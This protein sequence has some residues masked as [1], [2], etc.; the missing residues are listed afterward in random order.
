[1]YIEILFTEWPYPLLV[2]FLIF[3]L[4]LEVGD[5][6]ITIT[7]SMDE[8]KGAGVPSGKCELESGAIDGAKVSKVEDGATIVPIQ[9]IPKDRLREIFKYANGM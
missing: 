4:S 6:V 7:D 1:M 2:P 3:N 5:G 8:V 9:T